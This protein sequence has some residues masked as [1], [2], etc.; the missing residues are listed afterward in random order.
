MTNNVF[1][2]PATYYAR[3]LVLVLDNPR[4]ELNPALGRYGVAE[5]DDAQVEEAIASVREQPIDFRPWDATHLPSSRWLR[6]RKIYSVLHQDAAT[7]EM[8]AIVAHRRLREAVERLLIGN[9]PHQEVAFRLQ[10]LGYRVNESAVADFRHYFWNTEIMGAGDWAH[11][12]RSD[13]RGRTRDLQEQYDA[14]RISG[15]QFALYRTGIRVEIDRRKT[16]EEMHRELYF[17]FQEV[18]ALPLSDKKV[19]M[20]SNISR[21]VVRIEE[22]LEA[23]DTALADVLRKFERFRLVSAPGEVPSMRDLAPTGTISDRGRQVAQITAKET[24]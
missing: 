18:R 8:M 17:T 3:Y 22:R 15:P 11:Y 13:N 4:E 2:H 9:V 21:S 23:G 16:L 19:E 24:A 1:V 7:T 20:L 5:L 14:A 6:Q 10:E 12:Y